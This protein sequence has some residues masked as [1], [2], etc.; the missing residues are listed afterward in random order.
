MD[1]VISAAESSD[2]PFSHNGWHEV[3][4]KAYSS[5]DLLVASVYKLSQTCRCDSF[6]FNTALA[7][8]HTSTDVMRAVSLL[9]LT[10]AILLVMTYGCSSPCRFST[11]VRAG[12]TRHQTQCAIHRTAQILRMEQ[13]KAQKMCKQTGS[14]L[15]QR[16]ERM[17]V[18]TS[19]S[20]Q[21]TGM[22]TSF[23]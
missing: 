19:E 2:S 7:A 6:K 14:K 1:D 8:L 20:V 9:C 13:R 12:L 4:N 18:S 15:E 3:N 22:L 10:F 21:H 16:K 23:F 5:P 17:E 11:T